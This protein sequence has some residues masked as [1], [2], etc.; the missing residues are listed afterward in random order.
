MK[1]NKKGRAI[2]NFLALIIIGVGRSLKP[3]EAELDRERGSIA[4]LFKKG[5]SAA[6]R[7]K[8]YPIWGKVTSKYS[9]GDRRSRNLT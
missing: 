3:L 2:P 8:S 5:L 1:E 6:K 7:P 4:K 9:E